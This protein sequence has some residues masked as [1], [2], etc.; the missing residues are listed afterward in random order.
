MA[1]RRC[2]I[3][4]YCRKAIPC[5]IAADGHHSTK[6]ARCAA[7]VAS[8]RADTHTVPRGPVRHDAYDIQYRKSLRL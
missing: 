8:V 4:Q 5:F 1:L 6:Q 7:Y 2:G 3:S